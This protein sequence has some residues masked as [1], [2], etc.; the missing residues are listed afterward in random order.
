MAKT[1]I[2]TSDTGEKFELVEYDADDSG[3]V[4]VLKPLELKPLEQK[5]SSW[6]IESSIIPD[7]SQDYINISWRTKEQAE[8]LRDCFKVVMEYITADYG[9]LGIG[10]AVGYDKIRDS[11][12]NARKVF[13]SD[14]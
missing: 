12:L 7:L 1:R 14:V 11:L 4:Y 2:V 13:N 10:S 9:R 3:S 5:E 8:A 6:V